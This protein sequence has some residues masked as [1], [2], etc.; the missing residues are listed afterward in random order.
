MF[1]GE[2]R[3]VEFADERFVE[4]AA[5]QFRPR[6]EPGQFVTAVSDGPAAPDESAVAPLSIG[7]I[8]LNRSP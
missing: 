4:L 7:S 3:P 6:L 1:D 2:L 8:G 5:R